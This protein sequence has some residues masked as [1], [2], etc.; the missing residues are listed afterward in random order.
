MILVAPVVPSQPVRF[1]SP[2]VVPFVAAS[3]AGWTAETAHTGEFR[4]T[5]IFGRARLPLLPIYGVGALIVLFLAKR[6]RHKPLAYR[7]A[8][9]AATL[10]AFEYASCRAADAFFGGRGARSW[11]Y[12]KDGIDPGGCTS[13]SHTVM[14]T[15]A[16]LTLEAFARSRARRRKDVRSA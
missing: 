16:A 3:A 9:Y 2:L 11:D 4:T 15:S 8:V 1:G 6:L 14:W 12:G 5:P 10:T 13:L 7:A